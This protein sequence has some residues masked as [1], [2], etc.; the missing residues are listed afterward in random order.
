MSEHFAIDRVKIPCSCDLGRDHR[1]DVREVNSIRQA[2]ADEI[3]AVLTTRANELSDKAQQAGLAR[4]VHRLT[5][6]A[7]EARRSAQTAHALGR[8]DTT[9]GGDDG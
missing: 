8:S 4:D 5:A 6:R 1:G 3:A 7:V 9:G 2:T